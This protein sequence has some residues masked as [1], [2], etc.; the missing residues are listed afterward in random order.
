M[1]QKRRSSEGVQGSSF[2]NRAVALDD[3]YVLLYNESQ[4]LQR[5]LEE[6]QESKDEP[7]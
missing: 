7:F 3:N 6:V 1:N 4:K 5:K 2:Q